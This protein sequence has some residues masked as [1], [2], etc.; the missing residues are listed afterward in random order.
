MLVADFKLKDFEKSENES[1]QY[2]KHVLSKI[3]VV[4]PILIMPGCSKKLSLCLCVPV[5]NSLNGEVK[6]IALIEICCCETNNTQCFA[7]F[8]CATKYAID[9]LNEVERY[10]FCVEPLK[11]HKAI[12]SYSEHV[13]LIESTVYKLYNTIEHTSSPNYDVIKGIHENYLPDLNL[14]RLTDDSHFFACSTITL[15]QNI[16]RISVNF[17][18]SWRHLTNFTETVWFIQMCERKILCVL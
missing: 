5:S 4:T 9:H 16:L 12:Y 15:I 13:Y 17:C 2:Y 1:V 6:E 8:L 18:T 10:E 3:C 11:G 7:Q 14:L